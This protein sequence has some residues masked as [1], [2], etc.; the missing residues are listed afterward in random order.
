MKTMKTTVPYNFKKALTGIMLVT[1][2][3]FAACEKDPVK[4]N[5]NGGN[6]GNTQ[7]KHNVELVYGKD[8]TTQWQN[9]S[10]DTLNKYNKDE[11][12][13]SIF[14]IPEKTNQFAT[15]SATPFKNI[16]IPKLRERHNV[17]PKKVFGKG[18]LELSGVILDQNPEIVRFF[19]DTLKYNV[20]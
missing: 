20:R 18:D 16:I 4:P 9:I 3:V 14:M 8:Y 11:T 6:G 1:V 2:P 13:D 15:L 19:A 5:E 12:V 17:N 7:P 10:L